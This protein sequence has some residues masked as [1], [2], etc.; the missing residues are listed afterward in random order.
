MQVHPSQISPGEP[1]DV[2]YFLRNHTD[3]STYYIRAV[4][5]DVHT[6]EVLETVDLDQS[7]TNERLFIKRLQAPPDPAG[8]GRNIVAIATVYTDS[9]YTT[10]SDNY[11]EQE[12]YFLIKAQAPIVGGG[13]VDY[14]VVRDIIQ[15]ELGKLPKPQELKLPD[16]PDMSFVDALLGRLSELKAAVNGLPKKGTDLDPISQTLEAIR[17]AV[18]SLPAPQK[19]NL[20]GLASGLDAIHSLLETVPQQLAKDNANLIASFEAAL[21]RAVAEMKQAIQTAFQDNELSVSMPMMSSIQARPKKT[22]AT[23]V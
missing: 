22:D 19:T 17:T 8:Y 16:Q 6:G 20:S 15:D 10:K 12:Q 21:K 3:E 23:T 14:R 1:F 5:Y 4:V 2:F 11:E 9:G 13:G 7:A 18:T